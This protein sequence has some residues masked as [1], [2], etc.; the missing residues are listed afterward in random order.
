MNVAAWGVGCVTGPITIRTVTF[1]KDL[2]EEGYDSDGDI[3]PSF[4]VDFDE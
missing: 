4:D 1:K 3:G 2:C